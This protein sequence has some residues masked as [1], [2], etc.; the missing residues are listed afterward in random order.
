MKTTGDQRRSGGGRAAGDGGAAAARQA[1]RP[2]RREARAACRRPGDLD[3]RRHRR[4]GRFAIVYILNNRGSSSSAGTPTA[5]S[6][7]VSADTS[8]TY[9][10]LVAR[11]NGLYDQGAPLIQ[12]SDFTGAC[13]VLRRCRQG[14]RGRLEEAAGRPGCGHRFRHLALLLRATSRAPS[15]RWTRSSR[16]PDLPER[17]VQQ[18]QLPRHAGACGA[19]ERARR[20][21]RQA[22][23]ARLK[24]LYRAAINADATSEQRPGGCAGAEESVS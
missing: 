3:P 22:L 13:A 5:P 9:A 18:R 20:Q 7:P 24:A 16:T 2:A 21:G 4:G 15:N 19:A 23:R 10:E 12:K 1:P 14:L 11:A 8:G 6:A 17:A